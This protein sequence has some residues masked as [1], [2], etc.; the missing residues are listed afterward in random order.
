MKYKLHL[1][2]SLGVCVQIDFAFLARDCPAV[3][4]PKFAA[5]L[6]FMQNLLAFLCQSSWP[7]RKRDTRRV[8]YRVKAK[9]FF[10]LLCKCSVQQNS[11]T[12][13]VV[14]FFIRDMISSSTSLSPEATCWLQP[15]VIAAMMVS[16]TAK[17]QEVFEGRGFGRR[18]M[19]N[20]G[21]DFRTEVAR[22]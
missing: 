20:D 5:W 7:I 16:K 3:V 22:Q 19:E 9:G 14:L 2:G 12:D 17:C 10:C 18:L 15:N 13:L 4:K 11:T 21:C 8:H 6:I 1:G